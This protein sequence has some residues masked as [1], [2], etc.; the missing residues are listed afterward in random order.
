VAAV[1]RLGVSDFAILKLLLRLGLRS[2]EVAKLTLDEINW[3]HGEIT[4]E[5]QGPM[6][7]TPLSD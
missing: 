2:R 5:A 6:R 1:L 7:T 3:R 4:V